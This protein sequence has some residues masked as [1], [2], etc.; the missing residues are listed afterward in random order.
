[1]SEC[2]NLDQSRTP[3]FDALR[4]FV[5]WDPAPFFIPA[6]KM[7][8]GIDPRFKSFAGENIF[9]LD[10][11]E[12]RWTDDFHGAASSIKEA[13]ELAADAW[14]AVKTH[15]LVNGT[16]GGIIASICAVCGEGEP[17]I[18]PRNAHKSAVYGLVVSGARPVYVEP[19]LDVGRGFVGGL[20][21][22]A[23]ERTFSENAGVRAVFTVS[24][25]YHGVMSDTAA[26][27]EIAHSHGA[28]LISDEA[29]GNHMYFNKRLPMGALELGA[30]IVC[31]STHKM[32]GA[33]TQASMLHL[34][35]G[36]A[37]R[38]DFDKLSANLSM[39]QTT[40]PSYILLASLD[41][42]RSYM[43]TQGE[44]L[45]D[46]VLDLLDRARADIGALPGIE[47]LGGEAVGGAGC[48][49]YVGSA[50]VWGYEPT[51]LV[52]SACGLG[53]DG[54]GLFDVLRE[55]YGVECEFADPMWVVCVAG[56]GTTARDT[57]TLVG[58]LRE[59]S[60]ERG[61]EQEMCGSVRSDKAGEQGCGSVRPSAAVLPPMP[62]LRMT[63]REAWFADKETVPFEAAR[64]RTSVEMVV[65]YP[66]GIP[67]LC[68]GE[69]VTDEVH[70]Y[71]AEQ[72]RAGRHMHSA[73]GDGLETLLVVK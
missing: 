60:G 36:A 35:S 33:L 13:Q 12:V 55:R 57:E 72:R 66:P 68:P 10:L 47:V 56:I 41:M 69:V 32:S 4:K 51:R 25:T 3:L 22:A 23:L 73:A 43:A 70:D 18:V 54:Y 29:H 16:S 38:V 40:S 7:G 14:G 45:L 2:Y 50:G 15:F 19:E 31:Q 21:P 67:V 5:D 58:A 62:P 6:H 37:R 63:P 64:G 11:C 49:P 8:V 46:G 20:S 27:A 52:V 44:V 48:R 61:G 1:M 65:P 9:K 24:P 42:A 30:D 39:M 17:I 34:G 28:V 71:L 53:L 59:V 26:L